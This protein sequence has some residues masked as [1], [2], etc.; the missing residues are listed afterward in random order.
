[1]PK[2][3]KP[4][5]LAISSDQHAGSTVGLC[6]YSVS[7]GDGGNYKASKAQRWVWRKWRDGY[8]K[9]VKE[10]ASDL[11]VGYTVVLNGDVIEGVHH[12]TYQVITYNTSR[13]K[14]ITNRVLRPL[15]DDADSVYFIRG[16]PTH[17]GQQ[18]K[19]EEDIAENWE[20]VV[21]PNEFNFTWRILHLDVNRTRFNIAHHAPIGRLP[22]TRSNA[23]GKIS[24]SGE[25]NGY[26][27]YGKAPDVII[28]AHNHIHLD[29]GHLYPTRVIGLPSWQLPTGYIDRLDPDA[30]ADIGGYIFV[31]WPDGTYEAEDIIFTPKP[32]K[33]ERLRS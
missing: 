7:L 21:R 18:A 31:C 26:R 3:R 2:K 17:V 12:N 16:T 11:G 15:L 32:A 28:R 30:L 13:Q 22:W 29:S 4:I 6:P 14:T 5:V 10:V 1:M 8:V 9:R 23:L 19:L 33:V 24:I 27:R 20:N 25:L